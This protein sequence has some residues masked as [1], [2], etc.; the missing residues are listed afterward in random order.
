MNHIEKLDHEKKFIEN[1]DCGIFPRED[2]YGG[3]AAGRTDSFDLRDCGK[4]RDSAIECPPGTAVT[5]QGR[6]D[7]QEAGT[8]VRGRSESPETAGCSGRRFGQESV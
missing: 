4:F 8:R 6:I 1:T 3:I 7:R 2:Q 5:G